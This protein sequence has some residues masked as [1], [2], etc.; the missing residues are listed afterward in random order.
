MSSRT[1]LAAALCVALGLAACG[2]RDDTPEPETA[3]AETA[4]VSRQAADQAARQQ[5]AAD[6]ALAALSAD[7][8]R[9][10]AGQ[11]YQDSRLY[12]PPG[13]NAMEYYLALRD[14][15]RGDA[16]ATSALIDLLPLTVIATEQNRDR[17]DFA[18]ARRL[19]GL[20]ERA[21]ATH[22]AL[23]RLRTSIATAEEAAVRQQRGAAQEAERQ[24]QI[25][26]ERA[27]QQRE[28]QVSASQQL[29]GPPP[30]D[31]TSAR[32]A[33]ASAPTPTPA[34]P[35]PRPA[36][37]TPRPAPARPA[38]TP[39]P[40]NEAPPPEAAP[41]PAPVQLHP[42]STPAP[43]Y[44]PDA[45]RAGISGE[46]QV[47][48]TVAVDGSVNSARIVRADPPRTFDREALSAV[49]RWRFEP[50]PAPVTTRRT[51]GFSPTAN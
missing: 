44:P 18:E 21:D 42:L 31:T 46:V 27:Q 17:G 34:Q 4:D 32:S 15:T 25:A 49:R 10:A 7:D 2:G 22:P 33:P 5:R 19:L 40:A 51:I 1:G 47:E 23:A 38:P 26:R 41:A 14:K 13:E 37:D 11:A 35:A 45:L 36:Q 29:P 20:I 9:K 24:Q 6:D 30:A 12:F 16:A 39:A 3:P 43:R 48:F 8:L 50:V 28:Q